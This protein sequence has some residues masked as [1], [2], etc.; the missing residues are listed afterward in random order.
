MV[1]EAVAEDG[2][3]AVLEAAALEADVLVRERAVVVRREL[4]EDQLA[5]RAAV[6][7]PHA[8][9]LDD[10][11]LQA[12]EVLIG[13]DLLDRVD[14]RLQLRRLDVAHLDLELQRL[15]PRVRQREVEP[16]LLRADLLHLEDRHVVRLAERLLVLLALQQ[17]LEHLPV[18]LREHLLHALH[19]RLPTR[20]LL[21][22]NDRRNPALNLVPLL[23]FFESVLLL[24]VLR[25]VSVRVLL[26]LVRELLALR[27]L[28]RLAPRVVAPNRR[29]GSHRVKPLELNGRLA[30]V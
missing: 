25:L 23:L 10:V 19:L 20:R 18:Q 21:L 7:A 2:L 29:E 4:A 28:L 27:L 16:E 14:D 1:Q 17:R 9:R 5:D 6:P 30:L 26:R 22:R 15:E 11:P 12:E 24:L 8:D 13:D 3:L